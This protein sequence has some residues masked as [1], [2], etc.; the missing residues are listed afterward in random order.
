MTTETAQIQDAAASVLTWTPLGDDRWGYVG[1]PG[2]YRVCVHRHSGGGIN[3]NIGGICG[4]TVY[5]YVGV[6]PIEIGTA[7]NL[8]AAKA[9]AERHA[10]QMNKQ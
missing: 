4:Y 2:D 6:R 1:Q 7:K 9:I 5:Q 8:P 3:L 10:A